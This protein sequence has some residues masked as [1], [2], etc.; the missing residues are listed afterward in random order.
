MKTVSSSFV[1]KLIE[2]APSKG[3]ADTGFAEAQLEG[4]VS[5]FNMLMRNKCAYLADEVG[6][7]K[8]YIALGVM[9][10]LRYFN[11]RAR[12]VVITPRENIQRKWIKELEN[13]VHNNWKSVGNRV[14]S[15]QGRPAWEPVYCNSLINFID[16]VLL[17]SNR[18]FF[19]RMPSFS[20]R[21]GEIESQKRL[22]AE[23]LKLLPWIDG[24]TLL[25]TDPIKFADTFGSILNAA[26]P[27]IDLLV[28]DEAHKL[29]HGFHKR[30]SMRNRIMALLFGHPYGDK[31]EF[32]WYKPKIKHTLFLSA[33]PFEEEYGAVHRQFDIFGFGNKII[34]SPDSNGN[35]KMSELSSPELKDIE[36]QKILSQLM[37]RRVAALKIG[38]EEYTKNMYRRE[39]RRGGYKNHDDSMSID[40]PK[41]RLVVALMQK[42]VAEILQDEKF[43]NH[44]QIG[45]LSSFESFLQSVKTKLKT[46]EK[47]KLDD[48][49]EK[50]EFYGEEQNYVCS[51]EE[52][53][54]IDTDVINN[55]VENYNKNFGEKLPH[56]KLDSTADSLKESFTTGKKTLVFVRRVATVDELAYKLDRFFDNWI[57]AKM[58]KELPALRNDIE[59]IFKKYENERFGQVSVEDNELLKE[60]GEAED[61]LGDRSYIDYEDEGSSESFFSWFFRGKGPPNILSGAAFQKNRLSSTSSVYATLFEDDHVSW[62]LG[63]PENVIEKIADLTKINKSKLIDQLRDKAF[64]IFSM[65]S[66]QKKGY[67]RLYVFEAYQMAA[68]DLLRKK[69]SGVIGEKA[70]IVLVSRYDDATSKPEISPKGFP[71]P[72]EGLGIST[73]FTELVKDDSLRKDIW[74]DEPIEDFRDKF[75]RREQRREL[76]S[77]TCR[78]GISYIDLYLLAVQNIGSFSL[79][80]QSKSEDTE[81]SLI[82]VF[83]KLL[84]KQK[85]EFGLSAYYELSSIS[86]AFD[87]IL[88]VNF[89]TLH[90][91][92]LRELATK[93]GAVLQRQVPVGRM[94]GGV[95]K[96]LVKQFRMPGFP[97][98]LVTTD[99][100]QEGEDLHTFCKNV[101]HYGIA[102]TPSAL[103]QRV[104]RVDRIGSL[105]QRYYDG[106]HT[107]PG[108]DEF[109]QVYYPHLSDTVEVLQ[110]RRV[111][112]R[113]NRFLKMIHKSNQGIEDLDNKINTAEEILDEVMYIPQIK[114]PLESAFS[115]DRKWLQG[116]LKA[117]DAI[118]V[119]YLKEFVPFFNML[120]G[121][122]IR[123]ELVKD[124]CIVKDPRFK[125]GIAN[126]VNEELSTFL[127][128]ADGVEQ[129][130]RLEMRSQVS[131]DSTLLRCDSEV[132]YLDLK[133]NNILDQLYELDKDLGQVKICASR[134]VK[135]HADYITIE[136]D[137]LFNPKTTQIEEV[138]ALIKRTVEAAAIIKK[139][140]N[141]SLRKKL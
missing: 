34:H 56:P 129:H 19:L 32:D 79:G 119:N 47:K 31:L 125:E 71:E 21:V 115:I 58:E 24:R 42:K 114:V 63:R 127:N 126:I 45:M 5:V 60:T 3:F 110:V 91:T 68:L 6:T 130:F 49:G 26:L 98:V 94:A 61:E 38:G 10:L 54:G 62:I 124:A 84:N 107:V 18:D 29:K 8:T 48:E 13:F 93:Y 101:I 57:R 17:N 78:L 87:L 28:V 4:A 112:T 80:K 69:V 39:W 7:G 95:N 133:N 16:E 30:T 108:E 90:A 53:K 100:L 12:I 65:H 103:E 44:F 64:G 85:N 23:I 109:L 123:K 66:Q 74:P 2:F 22:K 51:K 89:P 136:G 82:N 88:N 27:K 120:W 135:R 122:L 96:R 102:W 138:I 67:P 70:G 14:K 15:L 9:S 43:N 1:K 46:S 118:V 75:L 121:K 92:P 117:K 35:S 83:I 86:K 55:L 37:V 20:L 41:Q 128:D 104:G 50:T 141:D 25:S 137:I 113:L 72:E 99:V 131:G 97:I 132:G 134:D 36:K 59:N 40:D 52:R 140:M 139:E 116:E 77:A 105:F 11:P 33:T 76:I 111:L 106:H 81:S 73:F